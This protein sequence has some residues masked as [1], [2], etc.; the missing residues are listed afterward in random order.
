MCVCVC[1]C[2]CVYVHSLC[3]S[4]KVCMHVYVQKNH[5]EKPKMGTIRG[6]DFATQDL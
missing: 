1:V 4:F 5:K 6:Q 2:V 3:S